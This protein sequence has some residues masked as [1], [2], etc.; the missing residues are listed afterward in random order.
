MAVATRYREEGRRGG[1]IQAWYLTMRIIDAVLISEFPAMRRGAKFTLSAGALGNDF[2]GNFEGI[3]RSGVSQNRRIALLGRSDSHELMAARSLGG[4]FVGG[5][6]WM[7]DEIR[8][9]HACTP[10]FSQRVRVN[11][12]NR[13]FFTNWLSLDKCSETHRMEQSARH[14][15]LQVPAYVYPIVRIDTPIDQTD[16]TQKITV[17]KVLTSQSDAEAEVSRLSQVNAHK[18]CLYFYLCLRADRTGSMSAIGIYRQL[19]WPRSMNSFAV[20]GAHTPA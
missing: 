18:S 7:V 6:P 10:L 2:H 14:A 17:V 13:R 1:K 15:P 16:P 5:Q 8:R 11:E 9:Q 4:F 12:C 19:T 3:S 20:V